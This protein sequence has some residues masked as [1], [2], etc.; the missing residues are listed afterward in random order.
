MKKVLSHLLIA[1]ALMWA[2]TMV[3]AVDTDGDSVE[4]VVDLDDDNY[5]ILDTDECPSDITNFTINETIKT[6]FDIPVSGQIIVGDVTGDGMP[7]IIAA[8]NSHGFVV[9]K[10]DG[11]DFADDTTDIVIELTN[12][13]GGEPVSHPALADFDGDGAAEIVVAGSDDYIYIFKNGT[14]S[15]SGGTYWI[16]SD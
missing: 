7:N 12:R 10:G 9:L 16:K 4:D 11:S 13:E 15:V 14:G 1:M 2:P 6:K 8:R 3:F 5:G